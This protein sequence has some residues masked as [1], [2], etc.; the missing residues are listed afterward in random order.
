MNNKIPKALALYYYPEYDREILIIGIFADEENMTFDNPLSYKIWDESGR[1]D[2]YDLE[3]WE[4]L[5]TREEIKTHYI[6]LL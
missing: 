2:K 4:Y 3:E 5:P 6:N 1:L